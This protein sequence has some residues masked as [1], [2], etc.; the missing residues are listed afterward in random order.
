MKLVVLT[1]ALPRPAA[2]YRS[3][4]ANTKN[5]K[6]DAS[7]NSIHGSEDD[8]IDE[9]LEAVVNSFEGSITLQILRSWYASGQISPC[10]LVSREASARRLETTVLDGARC[11]LLVEDL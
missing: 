2:E 11:F 3:R 4:E 1:V 9:S 7:I 5:T 8:A 6:N 10:G